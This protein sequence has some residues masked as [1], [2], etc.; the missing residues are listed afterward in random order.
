MDMR[1]RGEAVMQYGCDAFRRPGCADHREHRDAA[2][3]LEADPCSSAPRYFFIR[4]HSFSRQA[5]MASSSRSTAR[6]A[7]RCRLQP[8]LVRRIVHV[9][10]GP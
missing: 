4:G 5:T 8:S 1:L 2:F 3:V 7:G 6:R 10:V 9:W